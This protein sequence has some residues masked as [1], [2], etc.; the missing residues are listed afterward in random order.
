MTDSGDE[1]NRMYR[2]AKELIDE[3]NKLHEEML[4]LFASV[5]LADRVPDD[6]GDS[7]TVCAPDDAQHARAVALLD[8]Y[9][10]WSRVV[11]AFLRRA[12]PVAATAF[13][14]VTKD[15]GTYFLL[16]RTGTGIGHDMWRRLF[17]YE[18]RRL[19][20]DQ[21][22]MI[23][24]HAD[25]LTFT[26]VNAVKSVDLDVTIGGGRDRYT[27]D[28]RSILGS[29]TGEFILPYGPR[30]IE[31][32]VLRHCRPRSGTRHVVPSAVSP[33]AIFGK[34]LFDALMAGE[35]RDMF[36]ALR[37]H[38]RHND[39]GVR[40]RLRQSAVPE[41]NRVPWEFLFDGS[42]FLCLEPRFSI[43]RHSDRTLAPPPLRVRYPL[44]VLTTICSPG[45][46]QPLDVEEEKKRLTTALAP[47]IEMGCVNLTYTRDGQL[48]TLQ[49]TLAQ[50]ERAG[51]PFHV[52]HFIGH[53]AF[54]EREQIGHLYFDTEFGSRRVTGFE[55]ATLFRDHD[56]LRLIVINACESATTDDSDAMSGIAGSLVERGIPTVVAMQFPISD[57]AALVFAGEFYALIAAGVPVDSAITEV[58]RSLFLQAHYGEWATPVVFTRAH[59][60]TLF[61]V[62]AEPGGDPHDKQ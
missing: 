60:G 54:D 48:P 47:Y 18:S 57:R 27:I 42:D 25:E 24:R 15:L 9:L 7:E 51:R 50:A 58:R 8:R 41:L 46:L 55:L 10:S 39:V 40:L 45:D 1:V 34:G 33:F 53:G 32:F 3:I 59:D 35:A 2:S 56:P 6:G 26:A 21:T 44:R 29:A 38:A 11:V 61:T 52:W 43:V 13:T 19:L 28:L 37:A 17:A 14:A 4:S 62:V 23:E 49:R 20:Q 36:Q 22:D 30:D 16:R 5:T 12:D 31:N